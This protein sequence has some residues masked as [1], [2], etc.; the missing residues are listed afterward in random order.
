MY[1]HGAV[2][3]CACAAP[4]TIRVSFLFRLVT[5]ALSPPLSLPQR[6]RPQIA[7]YLYAIFGARKVLRRA[8]HMGS[9]ARNIPYLN[10]HPIAVTFSHCLTH[11]RAKPQHQV[12]QHLVVGQA[13]TVR[14]LLYVL[15]SKFFPSPPTSQG[16][17]GVL[18]HCLRRPTT[19]GALKTGAGITRV[20]VL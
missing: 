10:L 7:E 3:G 4:D 14:E 17:G 16:C 13:M 1:V 2:Q 12:R 8:V 19:S 6:A 9:L 11:G 5:H 15:C 20:S 18:C